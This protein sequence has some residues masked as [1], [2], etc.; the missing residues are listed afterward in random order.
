MRCFHLS[1]LCLAFLV[2][3]PTLVA[4]NGV[5]L[6]QNGFAYFLWTERDTYATYE[7]VPIR[8]SVTNISG[9]TINYLSP[10]GEVFMCVRVWDPLEPVSPWHPESVVVWESGCFCVA[11]ISEQS[12]GPGDSYVREPV[13]DMSNMNTGTLIQRTGTH[14][15]DAVFAAY[16]DEWNSLGC[17]LSLQ[18]EVTPVAASVPEREPTWGAIKALCR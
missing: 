2:A 6:E 9:D 11:V 16:D 10:C 14:T 17:S 15:L 3:V 18:F 13:W 7:H 12:I 1:A 5:Y 4:A 8:F